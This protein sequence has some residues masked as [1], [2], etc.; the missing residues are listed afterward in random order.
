LGEFDICYG[1]VLEI[2]N[3]DSGSA[4][5]KQYVQ[6]SMHGINGIGLMVWF[7]LVVVYYEIEW[8]G[9]WKQR[10]VNARHSILLPLVHHPSMVIVHLVFLWLSSDI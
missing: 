1:M 5:G 9:G 8:S 7:W 6:V 2:V 3:M 10:A 4:I